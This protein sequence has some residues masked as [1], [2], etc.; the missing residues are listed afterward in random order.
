M[1]LCNGMTLEEVAA[2]MFL[3]LSAVKR[4]L[5]AAKDNAEAKTT[6]HLASKV[7]AGELLFHTPDGMSMNQ[8]VQAEADSSPFS[9]GGTIETLP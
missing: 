8:T 9:Q 1:H 3:S 7:I 6:V 4:H 5:A 2:E